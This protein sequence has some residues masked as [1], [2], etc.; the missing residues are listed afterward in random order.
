MHFGLDGVKHL[1]YIGPATTK[2]HH[3]APSQRAPHK[4]IICISLEKAALARLDAVAAKLGLN[5]TDALKLAIAE[6]VASREKED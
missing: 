2:L 3:M 1:C 5:R 4:Q 6:L